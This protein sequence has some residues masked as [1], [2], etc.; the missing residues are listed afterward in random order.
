MPLINNHEKLLKLIYGRQ[1]G[2]N[3]QIGQISKRNHRLE[4]EQKLSSNQLC[5]YAY[6]FSFIYNFRISF[7]N[8]LMIFLFC[9]TNHQLPM[10]KDG[11][12]GGI[13]LMNVT[14]INKLPQNWVDTNMAIYDKY[15]A[16]ITMADQDILNIYFN[17]VSIFN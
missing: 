11:V 15:K 14:R 6:A 17:K 13:M 4:N 3:R 9:Y 12:N 2:H 16:H 1:N 8:R 7:G 5:I 10:Y